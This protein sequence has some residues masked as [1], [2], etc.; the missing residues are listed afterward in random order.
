M[1]WGPTWARDK[2]ASL[3]LR[4]GLL[5]VETVQTATRLA[6]SRI[7][8]K[9]GILQE[10]HLKHACTNMQAKQICKHNKYWLHKTPSDLGREGNTVMPVMSGLGHYKH[11]SKGAWLSLHLS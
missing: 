4:P 2:T 11:R 9:D 5:M 1:Q 7:M 8:T 6:G 10:D 3:V